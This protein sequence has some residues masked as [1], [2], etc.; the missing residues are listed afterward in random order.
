MRLTIFV[1]TPG[2][3]KK[4]TRD[5]NRLFG[6][7][8]GRGG[9]GLAAGSC[10]ERTAFRSLVRLGAAGPEFVVLGGAGS[11][12][13]LKP[14]LRLTPVQYRTH[15]PAVLARC[16]APP[17]GRGRRGPGRPRAVRPRHAGDAA[18]VPELREHGDDRRG[19]AAGD[20]AA[21][22]GAAGRLC[23]AGAAAAE[24][25]PE[26]GAGARLGGW[27]AARPG[28]SVIACVRVHACV[29]GTSSPLSLTL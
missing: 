23:A 8:L 3:V 14:N 5:L 21:A 16:V 25:H 10:A 1:A 9:L 26:Q 20:T 27:A 17:P 29:L 2:L 7:L 6:P 24:R 28:R 11:H 4:R 15:G 19:A 13:C 18:P 12:S 22:V